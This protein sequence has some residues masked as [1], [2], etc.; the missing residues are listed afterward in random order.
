MIAGFFPCWRGCRNIISGIEGGIA[1]CSRPFTDDSRAASGP[2]AH[3][4]V[5]LGGG[6]GGWLRYL[7]ARK[8]FAVSD[9]ALADSSPAALAMA[10]EYLPSA[11][12][13]RQVDLMALPWSRRWSMAF[14]LDVLEHLPDQKIVLEQIREAL[15]PGGQLFITVPA[16]RG[17]WT[18]NDDVCRHLRRYCRQTSS[19][20]PRI[21]VSRCS[22]RVTSC[23]S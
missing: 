4:V 6:C 8:K 16:I 3:H 1:S 20:S 9:V 15:I 14:L 21:A 18:W 23:S 13:R 11:V 2:E 10:A 19:A 22:T 5:D 12:E 7:L 17:F